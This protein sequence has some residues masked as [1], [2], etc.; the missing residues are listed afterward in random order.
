MG[1]SSLTVT[2]RHRYGAPREVVFR[3]FSESAL[4]TQWFSPSPDIAV[5]ILDHELRPGGRYRFRYLLASGETN[6]VTGVFREISRPTRLMFTW[7]WEAPDPHAG[8]ETVV[9]IDFIADHGGTLVVVTHRGFPDGATRD[10]HYH[11]WLTTLARLPE[12]P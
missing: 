6:I 4:L 12:L 7:T 1:N 5:E 8:T 3:A 9:T 2:V 11:G 10:R